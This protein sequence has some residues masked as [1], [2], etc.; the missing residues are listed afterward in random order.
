[1]VVIDNWAYEA[2][3]LVMITAVFSRDLRSRLR[4]HATEATGTLAFCFLPSASSENSPS[5]IIRREVGCFVIGIGGIFQL[6]VVHRELTGLIDP[7]G[8]A[9]F[10]PGF[11]V[12]VLGVWMIIEPVVAGG[13]SFSF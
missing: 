4:L 6:N 2:V 7:F 5:I 13:V 10:A 8:V 3:A 11:V 12:L 1:L 9:W